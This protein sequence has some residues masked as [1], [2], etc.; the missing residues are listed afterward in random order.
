[1]PFDMNGDTRNCCGASPKIPTRGRIDLCTSDRHARA[2]RQKSF[3]R[4]T[5][6]NDLGINARSGEAK[7]W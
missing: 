3:L 7:K 1:V 4:E 6:Q 5:L 2:C